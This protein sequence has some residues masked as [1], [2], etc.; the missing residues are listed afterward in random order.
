MIDNITENAWE[1]YA[2]VEEMKKRNLEFEVTNVYKSF[3][4]TDTKLPN[5]T[6]A[7]A[8]LM[9]GTGYRLQTIRYFEDLGVKVY[10][11]SSTIE[12]GN[13]KFETSTIMRNKGINHIR[14]ILVPNF[15]L[16]VKGIAE[17]GT[18]VVI[19]PLWGTYGRGV[20][21]IINLEA[22]LGLLENEHY[23]LIIQRYVDT[24]GS[25]Y[26]VWIAEDEVIGVMKRTAPAGE[27]KTNISLGGRTESVSLDE[28]VYEM[29]LKS[30]K[31]LGAIFTGID[32][33]KEEI[34]GGNFYV[35]EINTQPDFK[36]F[37]S[38]TGVN[39]AKNM[40]DFIVKEAKK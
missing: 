10:N 30:T 22:D 5:F 32:V 1:T 7:L 21:K 23:P 34:D 36:G 6:I 38:C 13:N 33:V 14:T 26:R 20:E 15:E 3:F 18:P 8:R 25:D 4:D 19:K 9:M 11:T 2:I 12:I 24:N 39:P 28:S 29:C 40:V 37:Y 35:L 17:I 16:A 27:W 31:A